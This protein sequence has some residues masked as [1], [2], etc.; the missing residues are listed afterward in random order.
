MSDLVLRDDVEGV[1]RLTLHQPEKRNALSLAMLQALGTHLERLRAEPSVRVVIIRAAGPVFSSGHDLREIAA[2][3]PEQ[4]AEIFALCTEVMEWLPAL[5]QPVIAEVQGLATAAGCQ[6]A[7]SCDLVV[8]AESA[9]FATPGVKVG[10]FC[11]TPAVP[12]RS[13]LP[14][15]KALEMLLT[16]Q[17]LAASAALQLDMIN[18]VCPPAELEQVSLALARQIAQASPAVVAAGKRDFYRML[19]LSRSEA[20]AL[21]VPAMA[22]QAAAPACH[23]GIKA[24]FEKR[25]PVW[26]E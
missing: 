9:S 26:P 22:R 19:S 21:A 10:L 5:P 7:L 23:E 11:T 4:L 17:P 6:L 8:A 12:L 20:Y 18:R 3:S 25:P 13:A 2:S 15:K 1:A 24:F 16:G 14:P